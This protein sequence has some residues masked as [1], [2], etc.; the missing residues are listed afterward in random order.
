[1]SKIFLYISSPLVWALSLGAKTCVS[2]YSWIL[3]I[4]N[5]SMV[6]DDVEILNYADDYSFGEIP[7]I[8]KCFD[9]LAF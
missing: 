8:V 4:K 2:K 9:V 3:N 7:C 5:K 1:M 6:N